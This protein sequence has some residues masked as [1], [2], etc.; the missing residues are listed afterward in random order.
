M[1]TIRY[2]YIKNDIDELKNNA[3]P[4]LANNYTNKEWLAE[5]SILAPTNDIVDLINKDILKCIPELL[6]EST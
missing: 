5:R 3:Y 1:F 2:R 6:F 4:D